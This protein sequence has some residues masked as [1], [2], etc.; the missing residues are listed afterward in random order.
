MEGFAVVLDFFDYLPTS[1]CILTRC[2]SSLC[3]TVALIIPFSISGI[4]YNIFTILG[5]YPV[6]ME[7]KAELT[8]EYIDIYPT[9]LQN[10]TSLLNPD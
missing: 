2:K 6:R 8:V 1:F 4:K 3:E 9:L 5:Y 7:V 10:P